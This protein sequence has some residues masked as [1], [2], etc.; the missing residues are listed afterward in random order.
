MQRFDYEMARADF[1]IPN[2]FD[3]MAMSAIVK[4]GS[5]GKPA[6]KGGPERHKPLGEIVM[7]GC[8]TGKWN[9]SLG[10]VFTCMFS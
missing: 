2:R 9:S 5:K 3:V 7:E 1:G 6:G 10:M 8:F 4:S